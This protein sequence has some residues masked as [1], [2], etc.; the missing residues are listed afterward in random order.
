MTRNS[1]GL[2]TI[3]AL[4]LRLMSHCRQYKTT[5]SDRDHLN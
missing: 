4:L 2:Q 5:G 1:S 3:T